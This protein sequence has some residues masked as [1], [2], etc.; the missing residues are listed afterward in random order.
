VGNPL[1]LL[2]VLEELRVFGVHEELDQR[3]ATLLSPPPSKQPGEEPTVDDAFEHVLAR[4][5]A[6]HGAGPVQRV[7]EAIWASR[8]GLYTDEI[9]AIAEVPPATWAGI[10]NALDESLYESSGRINFGHDY[11]RKAVEDRYAITGDRRLALHRCVAEYFNLFEPDTR[12][13]E[14]LPWQWREAQS[15][16]ELR[17]CLMNLEMFSVLYSRDEYELLGYWVWLGDDVSKA[18]E[19]VFHDFA[20]DPGSQP[21]IPRELANFLSAA[22]YFSEFT[23]SLYRKVLHAE[24]NRLGHDHPDTL[25]SVAN[26]AGIL[27]EQGDYTAAEPFARRALKGMENALG[28]EHSDTLRCVSFLAVIVRQR[29]DYAAAEPLYRRALDGNEKVLGIDHPCTL[30]SVGNL[31]ILCAEQGDYASAERLLQRAVEGE[32]KTLGPDHPSTLTSVGNLGNLLRNKGDYA[33]A[34]RLLQRAV[35]SKEK[36]LGPDHPSTLASIGNLALL[37][38]EQG[39]YAAAQLLWRRVLAGF[40]TTLG[41]DHPDTLS[42]VNHLASLVDKQGD[43][44]AAELLYRRALA[45]RE[46]TLGADHPDTLASV[47]NLAILLHGQG[48]YPAAE[49][50]LRRAREGRER[51]LGH[52]HPATLACARLLAELLGILGKRAEAEE[53]YQQLLAQQEKTL[54]A[55][56]PSTLLTVSQLALLLYSWRDYPAAIPLHQRMLAASK[57]QLDQPHT[58]P[59]V[60]GLARMHYEQGEYA[61]AEPLYRSLIKTYEKTVGANARETLECAGMLANILS[62]QGKH[63]E[64]DA[65]YL[66]DLEGCESS[67]GPDHRDTLTSM[68]NLAV[69]LG[70]QGKYSDAE[71]LCRRALEGRE[72]ILGPDH[73]DTLTSVSN[74]AILLIGQRNYADAEPLLRR[75]S[76]GCEALYGR[77]DSDTQDAAERYAE[78]VDA[79]TLLPQEHEV[80]DP[81]GT[82]TNSIGMKFVPIPAGKF[83]MGSPED[84]PFVDPVEEFQHRV[85]ITKPFLLGMH[86]VTQSQYEKVTGENPSLFK[87]PNHPVEHLSWKEAHRFCE[88]LSS[89]PAEV[90]A[91][92]QYRLPTE[93]EWEYACRAGT[94]TT[95]NTGDTLELHQARFATMERSSPKPTAPVGS[96]PPNAWG[97]Y[98]MHGNVWEW[99]ADW[100]SAKYFKRSRVDDPA[101]PKRGTHHTLRGGS[102]SVE[103]H[104]CRSS[105]RGEAAEDGPEDPPAARFAVLGDFGI[106]VV[107]Q[108]SK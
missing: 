88:L 18:Y 55:E 107:C 15:R 77:D 57:H 87:G 37:L 31:S 8:A 84:C 32:E 54:G 106:R 44:A 24:E 71:P 34:E 11:L 20:D 41:P 72:R 48:D 68:S 92:R 30:A 58:L 97:L 96:Y 25:R 45:G 10:A 81:P 50:L 63:A 105:F 14:E 93:A 75:F 17:D 2:T 102:A 51:L 60:R 82:V 47:G 9:L 62:E 42:S 90:A 100:F 16:E 29:G 66:R 69:S 39:D 91:G 95:F 22:G 98:D 80:R 76:H 59:I 21:D 53:L 64:A 49:P 38:S 4:I 27:Q 56:H 86:Q 101:G 43:Y 94:T 36:T 33:A 35:E 89:L 7:M 19:K 5:E 104:E 70:D 28:P 40:E 103:A 23:V 12:I 6:D 26:L 3:L 61:N 85:R 52:S 67:L 108:Q 65:L 78:C 79:L 99:T 1:F 83:L 73:P 46:K 74:L 13:A